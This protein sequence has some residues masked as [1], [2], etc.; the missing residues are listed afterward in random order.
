MEVKRAYSYEDIERMA[1]KSVAVHPDWVP[2][3]GEPEL[4]NSNWLIYGGSGHGKTSYLLQMVKMLCQNGQKVHYN[5]SE[6]GLKKSFKMALKR[7]HLKGVVG[8]NY[9]QENVQ[10]LTERL[11]R[12]RQAKIVVI[13]SVQYFF[14]GMQSKHYFEFIN[15][16]KD[17]TFIWVSGAD[18]KNPR[19]K[20]AED[21]YYDADVVVNVKDFQACIVKNRFEAYESRIIWEK[22]YNERQSILIQKG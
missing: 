4:G 3:L 21:I 19:G 9:Q 12:R 1:F 15:R 22:G 2:H 10:E 18:G 13:D 17:T 14:R 8:F 6:E 11:S 16:F 5:T 7:N 20:I